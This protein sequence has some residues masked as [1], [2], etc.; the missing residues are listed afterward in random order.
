MTHPDRR[1]VGR[2][3]T[4][5]LETLRF[6][7]GSPSLESIVRCAKTRDYV[8]S[9]SSFTNLL[10]GRRT[11]LHTVEA[12]VIGCIEYARRRRPPIVVDPLDEDLRMWHALHAKVSGMLDERS[13]APSPRLIDD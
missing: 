5:R 12:F 4:T 8:V 13:T 10:A 9:K 2:S 3:L 6:H 1:E 11:R 7:V